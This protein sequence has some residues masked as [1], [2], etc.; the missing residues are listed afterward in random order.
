MFFLHFSLPARKTHVLQ[1]WR[2]AL[3]LFLV[4]RDLGPNGSAQTFTDTRR[5][6]PNETEAG[7]AKKAK[8][9]K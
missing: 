1:L 5:T 2:F 7:E 6:E 3:V 9:A 8:E 4:I